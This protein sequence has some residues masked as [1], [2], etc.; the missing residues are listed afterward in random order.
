[1]CPLCV[2]T[3]ALVATGIAS[4]GGA[5]ALVLK[6]RAARKRVEPESASFAEWVAALEGGADATSTTTSQFQGE[7][8][9]TEDRLVQ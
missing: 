1:M 4:G 7:R 9:A 2:S 6:F 3:L 5:T 8:N